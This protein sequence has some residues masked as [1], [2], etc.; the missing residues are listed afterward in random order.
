MHR[1]YAEM[2]R[3][4]TAVGKLL[5]ILAVED[6]IL[7]GTEDKERRRKEKQYVVFSN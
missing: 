4:Y 5:V 6:L 7:I 3:N 1:K 2:D